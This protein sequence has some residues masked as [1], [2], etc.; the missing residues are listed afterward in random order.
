M[1]RLLCYVMPHQGPGMLESPSFYSM[2][3]GKPDR[4]SLG[5]DLP[6]H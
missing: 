1:L 5:H 4:H 2:A 3:W 6:I